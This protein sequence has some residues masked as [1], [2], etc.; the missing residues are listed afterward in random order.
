MSG[1]RARIAWSIA[2]VAVCAAFL[3]PVVSMISGSFRGLGLAPP[4]SVELLPAGASVEGYRTAFSIVPLARSILNSLIVAAIAVPLT[5]LTASWAGYGISQL[6]P[7]RRT[8]F[9]VALLV[10]LTVPVSAL[11]LTRFAMFKAIGATDSF[12]PLIAPAILGG[13]PILVLL[14]FLAF[15]RVPP[16]IIDAARVEG[17]NEW[18][19]WRSVA[20]PL[21]K[22]TTVAV[23]LLAFALFWGN[24]IDPLLY[25]NSQERFTAPLVLRTLQQLDRTNWPVMLAGSVVVSAPVLVTFALALRLIVP[26]KG[27][28]WL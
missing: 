2:V 8:I 20:M 14:Y 18:H 27:A 26:R 10:I 24:F 1:T 15:R 11:W 9:V 12:I 25:V 3:L 13:S 21:V 5:I 22:S 6:E 4:R 28:G 19:I 7:R 17:A 16:D 23:G